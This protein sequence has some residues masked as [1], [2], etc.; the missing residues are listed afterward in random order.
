MRACEVVRVM[1][2]NSGKGH[3]QLSRDLGKA[4]TYIGATLSRGLDLK[5]ETLAAIA[6]NVTNVHVYS[7]NKPDVAQK[8]Q[9]NLSDILGK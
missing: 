3:R 7:M 8:I 9:S 6:N 2:R 1:A 5:V 4:E